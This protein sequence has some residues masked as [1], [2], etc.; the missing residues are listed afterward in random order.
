MPRLH[1]AV[2]LPGAMK[3]QQGGVAMAS[4]VGQSDEFVSLRDYRPGDPLQRVHWKSFARAGRQLLLSA[5]HDLATL[6]LAELLAVY[7]YRPHRMEAL[8]VICRDL[9]ATDHHRTVWALTSAVYVNGEIPPTTDVGLTVTAESPS[10]FSVRMPE[11]I[12]TPSS[13]ARKVPDKAEA[14]T[15]VG[16]WIPLSADAALPQAAAGQVLAAVHADA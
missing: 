12:E 11:A 13:R 10:G 15:I 3:Y 4:S 9:N 7:E 16:R 8:A 2:A 1:C 5:R 14:A 6:S